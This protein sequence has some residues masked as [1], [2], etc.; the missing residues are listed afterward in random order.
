MKIGVF[1]CHCGNNIAATVDVERVAQ[2]A[3]TLPGVVYT[4]TLHHAC[5]EPGQH[6]ILQTIRDKGL[7]QIV[8][9]ACSPRIHEDTF[10]RVLS[11]AGLNQYLL[12]I[13]N[14]REQCSWIH[15]DRE[16][17]TR[18]AME[19]VSMAVYKVS[20]HQPL[21]ASKV[22][23]NQRTLIIGGGIA[24]IQA[25]LDIAEGNHE[26]VF[27]ERNP[28]IGGNMA[29]MDKVFPTLDC[30]ACILS[31]KMVEVANHKNIT[32]YTY[33]E[34]EQVTGFIGNFT[35]SIRKKARFVDIEKC[36]GCEACMLKCPIK[37]PSEF[38][39]GLSHHPAVYI[40]FPLAVPRVPVI[41]KTR[42]T[43][44]L[45]KKCGL[46][47]KVCPSKAIDYEQQDEIVEEQFGAIIVATGYELMDWTVYGE[48]GH[49]KY[50]DVITSLQ[51]E[52]LLS[53]NGPTGGHI[54][55]PSDGKEPEVVAII[56]CVGSRDEAM[57]RPY[58]SSVCCMYTAKYT[59]LT[60]EHLPHSQVFVFYMDVRATG[61]LYEE[62]IRRAQEKYGARYVRGRVSKIYERN[63][64]MVL[65]GADTLLGQPVE[66]EADLVV[67]A[68]GITA[69]SGAVEL[70]NKLNISHDEYGFFTES[71]PK[72]RPVESSTPGIFIA[73]ACQGPK[74][75]PLTV[76][77]ASSAASKVLALITNKQLETSP[78]VAEV[79]MKGCVGCFRCLK[80]CPFN[81][82]EEQELRGGSKV[83]R[84][85]P[86]LCQGCGLCNATCL[87]GAIRLM[88]FTDDQLI[89]EVEVLCTLN[90]A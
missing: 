18:K 9:G 86:A 21:F 41:D 68:V 23:M 56:S 4:K 10:R 17:A 12:E 52:R 25:A 45:K 72:L 37:G 74:D 8:I 34:V 31:P 79:N 85:N 69:N 70:A 90:P 71:H 48:Y 35:V 5:S 65:Q 75:I 40:P 30:S 44:M 27:V 11:Q 19:L 88:G 16:L 66:L 28:S 1:I 39:L 14:I 58:C 2:Y 54:K 87:T 82:I 53:A 62:F 38:N 83:A 26:V 43:Y 67:L 3:L 22:G 89:S 32:L 15:Q 13:A 42:C 60:R 6:S 59:I 33:S 46:C 76:A 80:V 7:T 50:P 64:R 61:K 55:R 63:G 81:A 51:Y 36:T 47:Q 84:V 49:G 77:Q 29:R 20:R 57:G 73:G 78:L 24:G